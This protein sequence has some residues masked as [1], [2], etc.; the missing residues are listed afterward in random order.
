MQIG[1]IEA[2]RGDDI[3]SLPEVSYNAHWHCNDFTIS[4]SIV[5]T[6]KRG[7]FAILRD[8]FDEGGHE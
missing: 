3:V 5:R 6:V 7:F 2:T 4:A 1:T 8:Q